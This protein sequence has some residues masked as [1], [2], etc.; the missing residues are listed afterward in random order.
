VPLQ[1]GGAAA[2]ARLP[3]AGTKVTCEITGREKIWAAARICSPPKTW[4]HRYLMRLSVQVPALAAA[5]KLTKDSRYAKHAGRHLRAWFVD[6]ATRM[7][8]HIQYS[9]AIHG[10]STGR[11]IGVI[12]TTQLVEVAPAV[13]AL[14]GTL[15]HGSLRDCACAQPD[16]RRRKLPA[17]NEQDQAVRL[18]ETSSFV[19]PCF[20]WNRLYA[21]GRPLS[22][23]VLRS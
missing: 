12:D 2:D 22:V 6:P 15:S 21:R 4:P 7:N 9:Q 3:A 16:R 13:D 11:G 5:W 20:G 23:F 8:P 18:F 17:G 1:L 10:R 14:E 19:S